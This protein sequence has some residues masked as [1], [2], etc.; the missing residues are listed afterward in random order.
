MKKTIMIL[1][2]G[3]A[4]AGIA[5]ADSLSTAGGGPERAVAAYASAAKTLTAARGAVAICVNGEDI[6]FKSTGSFIYIR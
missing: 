1:L 5:A 3:A 6:R 4:F 2:A